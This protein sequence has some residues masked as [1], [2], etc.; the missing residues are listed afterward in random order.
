MRRPRRR[1]NFVTALLVL[2]V[3]AYVG[4]AIFAPW[5]APYDPFQPIMPLSPPSPE[6]WLG[7][8]Q[9]GRDVL[10]R[11]IFGARA[12]L[13]V[14]LASVAIGVLVGTTLGLTAGYVRR[15]EPLIMRLM[16]ALWAYPAVLLALGLG[17]AVGPGFLTVVSAIGIVYTPVFARLAFGQ[18]LAVKEREFVVGAEALGARPA[19]VVLRHILPNIQAALVVQFTLSV[20]TAMIFESTLSFLGLGIQPPT[21]SWGVI[22]RNGYSWMHIAPWIAIAPGIAIFGIVLSL[23]LLGDRLRV[24]LDP[25]SHGR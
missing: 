6:H 13:M 5:V 2:V 3:G 4:V 21:P 11:T 16:D 1:I 24:L 10:S 20:G 7:T 23:N 25:K 18:T 17:V 19:R 15:L 8:D 9:I 14:G 12:S 22:L